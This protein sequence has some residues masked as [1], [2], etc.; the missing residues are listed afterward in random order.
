M[1]D[2]VAGFFLVGIARL[3]F[4]M[5]FT[6]KHAHA[7][8][9]AARLLH[10][11]KHPLTRKLNHEGIGLSRT[12]ACERRHRGRSADQ[13][14]TRRNSARHVHGHLRVRPPHLNGAFPQPSPLILG[15]EFMGV[16]ED[17]GREVT[18]LR[19]GD[20]VVVPFPIACG[21]CWFCEHAAPTQC[22]HSN[23]EH[24]GPEGGLLSQK[25]GALFGYT[26]L[27]RL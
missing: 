5:D 19:R 3:G 24:Y 6:H 14:A 23:P 2:L 15:H 9:V 21:K 18:N 1:D 4:A 12:E 8:V 26:D 22:E 25:G 13:R 7:S 11:Y 10:A 17:V 27:R 16:V 20:R